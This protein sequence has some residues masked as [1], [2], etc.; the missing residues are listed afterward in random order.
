MEA[1]AA[2]PTSDEFSRSIPWDQL[3]EQLTG[4]FK[5]TRKENNVYFT[6]GP[7]NTKLMWRTPAHL[8]WKDSIFDKRNGNCLSFKIENDF[9]NKYKELLY[10]ISTNMQTQLIPLVGDEYTI[11]PLATQYIKYQI[12]VMYDA[13]AR[14]MTT[15]LRSE[16]VIIVDDIMY[17]GV[18]DLEH[19]KDL[20]PAE[21][22][23]ECMVEFSYI[24]IP[25][26]DKPKTIWPSLTLKGIKVTSKG[27][28]YTSNKPSGDGDESK[29]SN[30]SAM[31]QS[32]FDFDA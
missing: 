1:A 8:F 4:D 18:T 24:G 32:C 30:Q 7:D 20:L 22:R 16:I 15:T 10:D 11:Q 3:S 9:F 6:M 19:I 31:K 28:K 21:G 27:E 29:N 13:K 17:R 5:M 23:I 26:A 2:L 12:P 14:A 25:K